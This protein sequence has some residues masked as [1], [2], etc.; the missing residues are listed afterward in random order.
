MLQIRNR[1]SGAILLE[2]DADDLRGADL[3][4]ADLIIVTWRPWLTYITKGR[5]QIGC[6]SHKLEEWRNFSDEEIAE[7]G[8]RALYFWKLNKEIF[9]GLCERFEDSAKNS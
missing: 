6:Q 1:Y 4:G 3:R 2:V 8:P 9:I 5:I 7:M